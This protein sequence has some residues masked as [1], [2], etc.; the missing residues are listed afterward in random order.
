MAAHAEY[1]KR[2]QEKVAPLKEHFRDC[3]QCAVEFTDG[4]HTLQYSGPNFSG[5]TCEAGYNLVQSILV[6]D[7]GFGVGTLWPLPYIHWRGHK[8]KAP[9]SAPA[10]TPTSTPA[11]TPS[12]SDAFQLYR[13]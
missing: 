8:L 6:H 5:Q 2:W 10:P 11:P 9:I 12:I 7:G 3:K 4:D 1:E 13:A